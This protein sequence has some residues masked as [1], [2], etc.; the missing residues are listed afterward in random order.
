M[1]A[2]FRFEKKPG[3]VLYAADYNADT[4][5]PKLH[6]RNYMENVTLNTETAPKA[7]VLRASFSPVYVGY[8]LYNR[9]FMKGAVIKNTG[10][11]SAQTGIDM[12]YA[13]YRGGERIF[14]T[15]NYAFVANIEAGG[16]VTA[17][18]IL[19][20]V[21]IYVGNIIDEVEITIQ[22]LMRD[23]TGATVPGEMNI[24]QLWAVADV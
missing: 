2:G 9:I 18:F 23:Q 12:Q 13:F 5:L 4:A 14:S 6:L 15:T 17:D 21:G 8:I 20:S 11:A 3:D 22:L 16:S 10:T 24:P 1:S 7:V 19:N